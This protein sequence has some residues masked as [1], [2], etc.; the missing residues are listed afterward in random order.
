M[1]KNNFEME[2]LNKKMLANVINQKKKTD[3]SDYQASNYTEIGDYQV[4]NHLG[5][6]AY[7]NVKQA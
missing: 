7:A 5:A 3:S 1:P 6:G 2:S 4:T